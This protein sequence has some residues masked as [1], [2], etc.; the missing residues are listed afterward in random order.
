MT[1][2]ELSTIQQAAALRA[3]ELMDELMGKGVPMLKAVERAAE[4]AAKEFDLDA[5]VKEFE[6]SELLKAEAKKAKK[7]KKQGAKGVSG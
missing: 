3:G 6:E 1:R 2:K 7:A 4:Q 5:K